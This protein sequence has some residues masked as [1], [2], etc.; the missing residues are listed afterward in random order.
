[1]TPTLTP[2]TFK[3]YPAGAKAAETATVI[4]RRYFET[5]TAPARWW[6]DQMARARETLASLSVGGQTSPTP[7]PTSAPAALVASDAVPAP[8]VE[9]EPVAMEAAKPEPIAEVEPEPELASAEPF[10]IAPDDLTRLVGVGPKL[11]M[12]L[13][14]RGVVA[15]SQ[16][17]AWTEDDLAEM[18]K[19]LD[20]KG[21]AVRDA[22]VA[23]AR[24]FAA[25]TE[26]ATSH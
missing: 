5:T 15:F 9:L 21:R 18:D 6:I 8:V 7:A 11:A 2:P 4:W 17:A 12:G 13:A 26:G 24:R 19:A 14:E 16:I 1:M 25:S 20:L 10:A 3:L 22:W 23:Q